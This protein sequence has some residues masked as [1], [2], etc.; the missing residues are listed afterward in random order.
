MSR[1][2]W[3]SSLNKEFTTVVFSVAPS[4]N[5][6]SAARSLE[7][8]QIERWVASGL[9]VAED[10]FRKVIGYRHIPALLSA[11]KA[12]SKLSKKTIAKQAARISRRDPKLWVHWQMGA[13]R[14]SMIG[15]V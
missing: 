14:G 9:L 4:R 2:R 6:N 8:D 5:P 1:P 12:A 11:W 15:A 3:M 10:Q 13:R 7:G